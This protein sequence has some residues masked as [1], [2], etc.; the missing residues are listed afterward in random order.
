MYT[1]YQIA[2]VQNISLLDYVEGRG[3]ELIYSHSDVRLK[4]HDSLVISN[5]KWKWFSR[6]IGGGTLDFLIEYEVRGFKEAMQTLLGEK[7]I[8]EN[9]PQYK[10]HIEEQHESKKL[11]ELPYKNNSSFSIFFIPIGI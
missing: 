6:N 9:K 1:K 11:S 3:Y 5:N 10:E 2:K 8:D 7:G 4:E